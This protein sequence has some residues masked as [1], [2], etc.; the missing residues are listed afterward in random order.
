MSRTTKPLI[1]AT[2]GLLV[3]LTASLLQAGPQPPGDSM[4]SLPA[5]KALEY[6]RVTTT[7]ESVP[8][9]HSDLWNLMNAGKAY[10]NAAEILPRFH[11]PIP[12][13]GDTGISVFK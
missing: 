11:E 10:V 7:K 6:T 9:G 5:L 1:G 12:T 4:P 8:L 3:V 13:R 2:T